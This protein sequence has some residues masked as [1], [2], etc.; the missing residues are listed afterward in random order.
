MQYKNVRRR[1]RCRQTDLLLPSELL[2]LLLLHTNNV[3]VA[4]HVAPFRCPFDSRNNSAI[5]RS[6]SGKISTTRFHSRGSGRSGF[7]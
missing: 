7:S 5:I 2:L 3:C 4:Q 1:R 6:P